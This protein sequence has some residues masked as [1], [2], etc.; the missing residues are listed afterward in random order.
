MRENINKSNN[1]VHLY[2]F[3]NEVRI[4]PVGA[5]EARQ[6]INLKVATHETY[7]NDKGET[8]DRP[9]FHDVTM[10]TDDKKVINQYKKIA[11][12]LETNKSLA[13]GEKKTVHTVS[14][15]GFMVQR[16]KS[17]PDSE[18]TYRSIQVY[19]RPDNVIPGAKQQEKEPRNSVTVVGNI[20]SV[21]VIEDKKFAVV[22]FAHHYNVENAEGGKESQDMWI[23]VRISGE[24]SVSMDVVEALKKG[25]LK[26]GDFLR[27]G[28][29]LH[30]TS[31]EGQDGKKRFTMALDLTRSEKIEKK[32]AEAQE[33][34]AE[35][36]AEP[37]KKAA[38]KK[39]A[40]N[41]TAKKE[42]AKQAKK[43]AKKPV[44]QR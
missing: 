34:K 44:M 10:F 23:D 1:N 24:R 38:S 18:D 42:E 35:Q 11:L 9:T 43:S 3:I 13:E 20:G 31:Y 36:K 39:A 5:D 40:S 15:D 2:G 37:A 32:Q 26:K 27:I 25:D 33:Q 28:G 4:N 21:K 6:A 16:T 29:Q 30:N 22:S 17:V 19:A 7:K 41:K 14:L 8:M 12:D